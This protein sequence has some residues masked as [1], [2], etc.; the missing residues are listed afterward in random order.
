MPAPSSLH[1][2]AALSTF[3]SGYRNRNFIADK[4]CPMVMVE[5]RSDTYFQK[6]RKDASTIFED[7]V[8]PNTPAHEAD[9]EV[10]TTTYTVR[11]R[12]LVGYVSNEEIRN[13]DEPNKP[14]EDR[15]DNIMGRLMLAH[16]DRVATLLLAS[17]SYAAAN[18][19]AATAVWTNHSTSNPIKD[20]QT[21][22]AAIA[23]VGTDETKL[24]MGLG[25]EAWQALSRHPDILG[26]RPGGG[27]VGGVAKA[28]EIA[29]YL[30][31]DEIWVSDIQKNT[32]NR[33]LTAT[34]T[35]IW[36]TTKA[37]IMRV[38]R[39]EPR[40]YS[41]LFATTFRLRREGAESILV[42]EW[43]DMSRGVSGAVAVKVALS[44]VS[45]S[46]QNDMGYL[47]TSVT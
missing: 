40:G 30:G 20:I 4:L 3:A 32:A 36:D 41:S 26:L 42:Q 2:N 44:E 43:D 1:V 9:Y 13:A 28:D 22:V 12:A 5:K 47:L 21:A 35:R 8:G 10:A 31:L 11:D 18:T 38:P 6:N 24:V 23:P 15:V 45:A 34:Y 37:C 14:K 17:G 27:Q 39:N 16:E 19:G 29:A 33:A 46:I 25:L 7:L